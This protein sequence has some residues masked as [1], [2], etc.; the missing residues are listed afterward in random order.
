MK[1]ALAIYL[2]I[3]AI[4]GTV[5]WHA[6]GSPFLFVICTIVVLVYALFSIRSG[7]V[8]QIGKMITCALLVILCPLYYESTPYV[9]W[10]CL[11]ALAHVISATHCIREIHYPN[12]PGNIKFRPFI[13]TMGFYAALGLTFLM[14][15]ADLFN[16]DLFTGN[17]LAVVT[18]LLG[19]IAWEA[20]RVGRLRKGWVNHTLS[21]RKFNVRIAFMVG[22]AILFA[23]IFTTLLPLASDA[24]CNLAISQKEPPTLPNPQNTSVAKPSKP[25][26][27]QFNQAPDSNEAPEI[28]RLT[29]NATLP[30]RGRLELTDEVCVLIKFKNSADAESL[31]KEGPLYVRT[32]AVSEFKDDQWVSESSEGRW[33]KDSSDGRIDGKVEI[34]KP[35]SGEIAHDVFIPQSSGS[36]LPALSG[37]STFTLPEIYVL[38]DDWFQNLITG[39]IHYKAWSKSKNIL[40]LSDT[41][42]EAGNPGEAYIT[43]LSTPFGNGLS[44]IAGRLM[45]KRSDL[46]GRIDLLQQYFIT[47]FNYSLKIENTSD[48]PP[49]EN[50]LFVEKKGYCDFFASAA[51]LILRHMDIPSR[52]AYGYKDG[53]YDAA[54]DTWVFRGYNAHAWNEIY[55]KNFGWVICDFTP[56]SAESPLRSELPP[57]FDLANFKDA[58]AFVLED[59]GKQWNKIHSLKFFWI[60]AILGLGLFS[61]IVSFLF[62]NQSTPAKRAA[63]KTARERVV[64]DRQPEYF[65]EFLRMCKALGQH[66]Y[67]GQTL[68]EFHRI[69]KHSQ[70]C[71]DEFDDLAAYYYQSRYENAPQDDRSENGFIKRIREFG[72]A[73][74]SKPIT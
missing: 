66:R 50:F 64:R 8:A 74:T 40:S 6:G 24:L 20:G 25:S 41:K 4:E 62:R 3:L 69:L 18:S 27:S 72:K 23:L 65:L 49:L 30:M 11:F 58:G 16:M 47:E 34:H 2:F 21:G 32:L 57:P 61:V 44:E 51:A 42:L 10:L 54:S 67:E 55:L 13:F 59:E 22:G 46:S 38:P 26:P 9:L 45:N 60:P 14:L 17:I 19:L 48:L 28:T 68:M 7:P 12:E 52:V 33:L 36:V 29:G 71:N 39:D 53:E 43:K 56:P 31:I 37:V 15:H 35:L 1:I 73:K 70:F 63:E 5:A